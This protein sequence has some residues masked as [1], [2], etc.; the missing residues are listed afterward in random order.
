MLGLASSAGSEHPCL[1]LLFHGLERPGKGLGRE[2]KDTLGGTATPV[3]QVTSLV[4]VPT[5]V[6]GTI[7][8]SIK[9]NVD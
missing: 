9:K 2:G 1:S 7:R 6:L 3:F 5:T 4:P 8:D